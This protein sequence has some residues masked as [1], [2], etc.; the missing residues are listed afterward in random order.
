MRVNVYQVTFR[1]FTAMKFLDKEENCF[2]LD[3]LDAAIVEES[4]LEQLNESLEEPGALVE[5]ELA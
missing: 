1:L 5:E 2:Q 4:M 3:A